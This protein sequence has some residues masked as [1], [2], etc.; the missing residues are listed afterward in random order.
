MPLQYTGY[1]AVSHFLFSLIEGQT[2]KL[3][4]QTA[5]VSAHITNTRISGEFQ[6]NFI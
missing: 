5:L 1:L 6:K 2:I 3:P 4:P